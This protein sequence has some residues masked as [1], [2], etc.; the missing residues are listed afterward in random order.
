MP[1]DQAPPTI[2]NFLIN[3]PQ[4]S[5]QPRY[6]RNISQCAEC[7]KPVGTLGQVGNCSVC[8]GVICYRHGSGL[9]GMLQNYVCHNCKARQDAWQS[10]NQQPQSP[11]VAPQ[12]PLPQ[13]SAEAMI[14]RMAVAETLYQNDQRSDAESAI[15][16]IFNE[17]YSN[18]LFE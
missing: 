5:K 2:K 18:S 8:K 12:S 4:P 7:G 3:R 16:K 11:Q 10:Q 15:D 1:L 17:I 13:V 14:K 6:Q 9:R